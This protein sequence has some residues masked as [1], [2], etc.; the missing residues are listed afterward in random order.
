MNVI[1]FIAI[2][3]YFITLFFQTGKDREMFQQPREI[4]STQEDVKDEKRFQFQTILSYC[5]TYD[6]F[7]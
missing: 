4:V 7:S 3:P 5:M 1:D 6:F 2:L